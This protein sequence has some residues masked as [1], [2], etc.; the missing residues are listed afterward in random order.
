MSPPLCLHPDPI[1]LPSTHPLLWE[2][3]AD[4]LCL[5]CVPAD[6]EVQHGLQLTL[7]AAV[8]GAPAVPR[9]A[10]ARR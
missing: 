8:T 1:M 2:C 10:H 3:A 5:L 6:G 7:A 4:M 9:L